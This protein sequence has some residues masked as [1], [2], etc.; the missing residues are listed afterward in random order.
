[1]SATICLLPGWA[2]TTAD[3]EPLAA[4]LGPT[5]RVVQSPD[6]ANFLLGWSLGALR[7]LPHHRTA[8]GLI[9]I[10]GTARFCACDGYAPGVPEVSL[11]AL[12]KSLRRSPEQAL[13]SFHTL[14]AAPFSRDEADVAARV[15]GS[16][17]Q[18]VDVLADGLEELRSVDHRDCL[19]EVRCP[20]LLLHGERD[21]VI[22]VAASR[23]IADRLPTA[24]LRVHADAGHDLPLRDAKTLA[25]DIRCFIAA[26]GGGPA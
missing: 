10:S 12:Q 18:G 6:E 21:A 2:H 25:T 14:C 24:R 4:L 15:G 16:L 17:A 23:W 19:A 1:M 8:R 22:P 13:R 9:L 3:L 5:V 11:R 20:V 7:A 26:C